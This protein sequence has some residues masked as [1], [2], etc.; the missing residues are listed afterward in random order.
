MERKTHVNLS[1]A[2]YPGTTD[3]ESTSTCSLIYYYNSVSVLVQI[4]SYWKIKKNLEEISLRN[5]T[6]DT[7]MCGKI[8]YKH[9]PVSRPC[10][11]RSVTNTGLCQGHVWQELLRT[12][13]CVKAM[14]DKNC[15]EHWPVSR[16]CVTRT[17]TNT[18]LCQGHVIGP[19]LAFGKENQSAA[20]VKTEVRYVT[21]SCKAPAVAFWAFAA[22][23]CRT[24]LVQF[25][26]GESQ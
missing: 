14:C 5:V 17:V 20:D 16:P 10:V 23:N 13:A 22:D 2:F 18:G 7:A 21:C 1:S 6:E 26:G 24:H 11:A 9:W 25:G 8:C 15:Y 19:L 12:L 3:Q 4:V